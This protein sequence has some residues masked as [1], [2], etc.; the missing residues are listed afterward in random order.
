MR[1][2][3]IRGASILAV[4]GL[5]LAAVSVVAAQ[6]PPPAGPVLNIPTGDGEGTVT[7]NEF[8]PPRVTVAEGT[9][10]TWTIRSDE[11]HTVTF[12]GGQPMPGLFVFDLPGLPPA[13]N[14]QL[15]FP[16]PFP[17]LM[18]P[19]TANTF[20]GSGLIERG[21]S[22][23]VTFGATGTYD[24]LCALHPGMTG[25]VTVVS[26]G[27]AGITTQA[28]VDQYAATH[29]PTVHGPQLAELFA[30]RGIPVRTSAPNGAS[31]H[32]VRAGT[33]VHGD[34]V[35]LLQFMPEMVTVQQGDTVVWY[36]DYAQTPHT[37]TFRAEGQDPPEFLVPTLPDGTP[38]PP[39]PPP[40]PPE[41]TSGPPM[42]PRL[43]LGPAGAEIR[44]S[45]SYDGRSLYNSGIIGDPDPTHGGSWALTFDTP[46]VY[47]YLCVIHPGMVGTINVTPR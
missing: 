3:A 18:A 13:V 2:E 24:Y 26:P 40:A 5:L 7:I 29:T 6:P 4:L 32:F 43:A 30:T 46:G 20:A 17:A 21:Q 23:N 45:P 31:F 42:L 27:S 11:P 28:A 14:P 35:E 8:F 12:L 44:P 34:Q 15:F 1:K 9:T 19:L 33:G 16:A 22:F 38:L 25:T 39:G 37:V 36:N 47:Q 10:V 41:G